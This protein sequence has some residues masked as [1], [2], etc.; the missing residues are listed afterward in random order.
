LKAKNTA[1]LAAK[2]IALAQ[3]YAEVGQMPRALKA[4][5]EALALDRQENVLVPAAD[6]YLRSGRLREAS[7][8]AAELENKLQPQARAYA[9]IIDGNIALASG[10]R[11]SALDHFREATKLADFWLARFKMGVTYVEA[12]HYAEAL[13]ELEACQKRR[14][15]ATAIFLD[16]NPTFHYLATLPYWLGRAQEG[17]GQQAAAKA[18]YATFLSLRPDSAADPLVVDARKRSRS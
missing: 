4:V 12:G 10:R 6:I 18:N 11:A 3:S 15:E 14:G 17:V 13:A 5:K 8:L 9:K 2:Q 16:E 1:G 7:D